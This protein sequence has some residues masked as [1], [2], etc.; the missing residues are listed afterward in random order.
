MHPDISISDAADTGK[1]KNLNVLM[2]DDYTK[3]HPSNES[4]ATEE[5]ESL[6]FD[7]IKDNDTAT[8]NN[9]NR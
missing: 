6:G 4:G 5:L 3:S 9:R 1:I 8:T 7:I 2:I